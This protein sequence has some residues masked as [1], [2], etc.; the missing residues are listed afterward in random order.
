MALVRH[1]LR[2]RCASSE[3]CRWHGRRRE[4]RTV[5]SRRAG[6]CLETRLGLRQLGRRGGAVGLDSGDDEDLIAPD[7]RRGSARGSSAFRQGSSSAFQLTG[8]SALRQCRRRWSH[9]VVPVVESFRPR[10]GSVN[11]APPRPASSVRVVFFT[12]KLLP[13]D[14]SPPPHF[15]EK[16]VKPRAARD[17]RPAPSRSK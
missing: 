12:P 14:P 16:E 11:S 6:T 8:G 17:D 1:A 2:R 15:A 10:V 4:R 9:A 13:G 3:P 5:V 7:D